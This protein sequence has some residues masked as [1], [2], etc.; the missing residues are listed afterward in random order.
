MK[1]S[2]F[3]VIHELSDVKSNARLFGDAGEVTGGF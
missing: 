2:E 3:G 1:N